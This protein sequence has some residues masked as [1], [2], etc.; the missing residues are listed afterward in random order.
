MGNFFTLNEAISPKNYELFIMYWKDL[1]SIDRTSADTFLKHDSIWQLKYIEDLYTNYNNEDEGAIC[2]FIEQLK[3]CEI[4]LNDNPS[5]DIQFP[6]TDNGFLGGD[7]SKTFIT[8]ETQIR[9]NQDYNE[10]NLKNLW[11]VNFRNFW[12][13]KTYLF[14]NLILCGDV[15]K[16]I[17]LIGSSKHFNQIVERLKEF[18]QA[19]ENWKSGKFNYK[20]INRLYSLRI[21][22]E[23]SLTMDS[24][25]SERFFSLPE[26]GTECFELH[27]KTGDL[28]FHFFPNN[29][30]FKVYVGYIGTHLQ[31]VSN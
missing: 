17:L 6:S 5:I 23:T 12:S 21:S 9:N 8:E 18:N 2:V 31:T 25:G 30:T 16:Q 1:L 26:G 4:Y 10:F 15:Q 28:R 20:E 27:I 14:P 7:F 19:V 24:Y 13:K 22:P 29:V 3:Y 11:N